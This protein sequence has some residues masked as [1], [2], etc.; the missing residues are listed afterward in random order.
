MEWEYTLEGLTEEVA[1]H[2][3]T[4]HHTRYDSPG[5][6]VRASQNQRG[7]QLPVMRC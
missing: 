2:E 5:S 6:G 3:V 7:C 1:V 4:L